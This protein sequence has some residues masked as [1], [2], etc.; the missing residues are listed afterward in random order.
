[1]KYLV[2]GCG[3]IGKRHIRNLK[4]I[5]IE[6]ENI[7]AI[8]TRKDRQD[9]VKNL[10]V[11]KI[12]ENLDEALEGKKYDASIICSPTNLHTDQAIKLAENKINF[13]VEKPLCN[14]L[15]N[16]DK[17]VKLVEKNN[18]VVLVAYIFRF[19]PITKKVKEILEKNLIGKVLY[20][21]GEFSEY[22]PD[23]HP[24]EDYRSFYMAEKKQGGGSILDQSHIFDL[25]HYLLGNFKSVIGIVDKKS[26]LEVNA[27][28]VSEL[29]V[30]LKNDII[31]SLHTDIFGRG[32]K[33]FLEIK[34]EK[35]NIM[36]DFYEN[37]VTVYNADTSSQTAFK[38]FDK[39]FNNSYI[40]EL[41]HFNDCIKQNKKTIAGLEVGIDTMKLIEAAEKSSLEKKE[42]II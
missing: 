10:G 36:W 18:L 9:E 19:A 7:T 8:E 16:V 33:K 32:H 15:N 42:V 1:M 38:K 39:D 30:K 3:S 5:G 17:L 23:W 41:K 26:S 6:T 24:Y 34:G 4:A 28:D 12:Y 21:R 29:I 11:S 31:V 25:V 22:L 20:A 14:N 35:G 13:I 2:I 27:D 40:E 37:S